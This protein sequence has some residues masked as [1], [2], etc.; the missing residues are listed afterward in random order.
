MSIELCADEFESTL[1]IADGQVG[2]LLKAAGLAA[3]HKAGW[4]LLLL[5]VLKLLSL[6]EL[7]QGAGRS[8]LTYRVALLLHC[9]W[10]SSLSLC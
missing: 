7:V 1:E 2:S 5:A 4:V 9:N 10:K 6:G 3:E 8:Q